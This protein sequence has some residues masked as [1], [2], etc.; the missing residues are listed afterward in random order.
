MATFGTGK[1]SAFTYAGTSIS[2][3]V[4]NVDFSVDNKLLDVTCIGDKGLV[5]IP[6]FEEGKVGVEG[7]F[8]T[9]IDALIQSKRASGTA[10][11]FMYYPQGTASGKRTIAGSVVIGSYSVPTKPDEAVT[12]KLA[13]ETSGSVTSGTVA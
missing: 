6:A 1:D 4:N 13:F 8:D 3:Y 2:S 12:F 9:T 5:K 10:E 7:F 11:S